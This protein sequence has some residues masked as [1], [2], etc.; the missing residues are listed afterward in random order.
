MIQPLQNHTAQAVGYH[1][2]LLFEAANMQHRLP[3]IVHMEKN[4]HPFHCIINNL[5]VSSRC[6]KYKG[7]IHI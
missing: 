5:R 6:N 7:I 3:D 2:N 4:G 1:G